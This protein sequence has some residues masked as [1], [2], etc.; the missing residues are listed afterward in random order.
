MVVKQLIQQ[1][2]HQ[3]LDFKHTINSERKIAK[4]L[5]AFANTNGGKLLVGVKDN[6]KIKGVEIEEEKHIL[7]GAAEVFCKPPIPLT[8]S[9][10]R[11]D[12]KNILIVDVQKSEQKPH[13]AK[14]E[15]N[16]WWAYIRVM[17]QCLLATK[18]MLDVMKLDTKGLSSKLTYGTPEKRLLELIE[19]NGPIT[20][21]QF[22]KQANISRPRAIKI[23]VNMIR[24]RIIKV[25]SNEK[26]EYYSL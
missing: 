25:L 10:D 2:E 26:E 12:G 15:N 1:G 19:I 7:L 23:L 20:L 6:G 22:Y 13:L 21:K 4:T 17:D 5:V 18:V 14:D 16:K 24:M 11:V 8:F 9:V 3:S